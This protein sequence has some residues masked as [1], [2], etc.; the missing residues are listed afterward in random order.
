MHRL[1]PYL[2]LPEAP[3]TLLSPAPQP[4]PLLRQQQPNS[5]AIGACMA[6]ANGANNAATATLC[7]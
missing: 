7:R 3:H 5:A 2:P 4:T 6:F 1:A